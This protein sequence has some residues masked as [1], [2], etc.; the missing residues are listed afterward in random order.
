MGR[1]FPIVAAVLLLCSGSPESL[2]GPRATAA[3]VPKPPRHK[4]PL[5]CTIRAAPTC[6][7][8]Q[9]P[10]V[11]VEITNQT[12]KAI[13][14]VGSLDASD[15]KW[16]YPYCYFEVIGPDGK[17]AVKGIGRC[18]NMNTLR[19]KDFVK[20]PPRGKFNPYQR[21]DDYG[22]FSAHQLAAHNFNTPGE[23]R[24][25]FVYSAKEPNIA[26]W[27]GDGRDTVA[28]NEKLVNLFKQVPK[29]EI[30]SNEIKVIVVEPGKQ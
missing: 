23:Y 28:A 24:I 6:V 3:P 20:V 27:G 29:V 13:F 30:K 22:F 26:K 17:S 4:E 10:K 16:R 5:G 12:R 1:V 14:L 25:R 21:T 11:T 8:G 18:G 7:L 19:E 9:A 2:P 15:C